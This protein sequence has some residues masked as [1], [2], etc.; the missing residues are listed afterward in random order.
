[1]NCA[2]PVSSVGA[3]AHRETGE[4][5]SRSDSSEDLSGLCQRHSC[6]GNCL[7]S[8]GFKLWCAFPEL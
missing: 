7:K 5:C 2:F 3:A 4:Q 1:M 8:E 6:L